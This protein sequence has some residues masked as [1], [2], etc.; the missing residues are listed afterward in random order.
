MKSV[1]IYLENAAAAESFVQT[2][3]QFE[4]EYD[5]ALGSYT[6]DAKSILGVFALVSEK[7]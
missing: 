5:L 6:V 1:N 4:G 7:L 2:M 3:R